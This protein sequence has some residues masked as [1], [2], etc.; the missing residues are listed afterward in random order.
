MRRRGRGG[1]PQPSRTGRLTE[2]EKARLGRVREDAY[3]EADEL[4]AG[5][6]RWSTW[7]EAE[8][9]PAPRP[10]WVVTDLAAAD[11][12][13][14][15]LKTGKEADV[16][17]LERA[18]PGAPGCLL[19]AKRYRSAEHRLFHRDAGY[20]EGR[21]MRKSRENRAM[22]SRSSFGRNLIAEQWAVA[23]FAALGRLWA[24]GAPVPY[25]VQRDGTELLLEF[26]SADGRGAAPRLAQL[27]PGAGE[28]RELW[29]QLVAALEVL[30]GQGLAHGDLSAYNL[31]V[32]DGR[33][34]LIDLPQVVDVVANPAGVDF[35]ARDVANVAAWFAARGLPADIGDPGA[36]TAR[37]LTAAG[38]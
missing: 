30:A 6:D 1:D 28:L 20:L 31:L 27:R 35:L 4:P 37:L 21:R 14:G 15:V 10:G 8:Q 3:S 18:V 7:A 33:L 34:V 23:E 13:L 38:V 26:L 24:A 32:C 17:L 36:L 9:G 12:E 2:A 11:T 22:A 19:A 29:E 5:A 25:P 16:F